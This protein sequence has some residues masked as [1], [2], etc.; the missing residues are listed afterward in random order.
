MTQTT[1]ERTSEALERLKEGVSTLTTSDAWTR[2]LSMQGRFHKYSFGNVVLLMMQNA[3]AQHVAGF[4]AWKKLGRSVKKG[5][6]ALYVLAPKYFTKHVVTDDNGEEKEIKGRPVAFG[7]AP[8]FDISQTEGEDL[9]QVCT[10]LP[11]TQYGTEAMLRLMLSDFAQ[12]NGCKVE[13]GDAMGANGYYDRQNKLIVVSGGLSNAQ[14]VKTLAHEVGHMLLHN[15]DCDM[16]RADKELEAESVAFVV[17]HYYGIDSGSYSFGYLSCWQGGGEEAI[18]GLQASGQR[19]QKAA[20][21]VID[22][23]NAQ[24]QEAA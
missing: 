9:P 21:Q 8:V 23:I 20:S 19:I 22:W 15:D 3:D 12:D 10:K 7:L 2:Y 11:E 5:A 13:F 18:K 24:V 6:K 14:S 4:H 17:C 16:T 1:T